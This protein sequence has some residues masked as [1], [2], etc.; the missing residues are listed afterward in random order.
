MHTFSA[1]VDNKKLSRL[2]TEDLSF[3]E[4]SFHVA[5]P[6]GTEKGQES[7]YYYLKVVLLLLLWSC[8]VYEEDGGGR[9][10]SSIC[11]FFWS[12]I[13][14]ICTFC[15]Y[16]A[17]THAR[18]YAGNGTMLLHP[19]IHCDGHDAA[20]ALMD[21]SLDGPT[22]RDWSATHNDICTIWE[23]K[24]FDRSVLFSPDIASNCSYISLLV[25]HHL[26]HP[27]LWCSKPKAVERGMENLQCDPS[28][29]TYLH[30]RETIPFGCWLCVWG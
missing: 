22:W 12:S 8:F 7:S 25:D 17:W 6:T 24:D 30:W 28:K 3:L 23:L 20:V 1:Q 27:S 15:M 9:W 21:I 10:A 14:C 11:G 29:E 2:A 16:Y 5:F 18:C 19:C 4:T 13:M 26:C